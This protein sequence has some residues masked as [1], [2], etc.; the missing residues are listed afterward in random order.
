MQQIFQ[1]VLDLL[2]FFGL[3]H[4]YDRFEE[5]YK[6]NLEVE[7]PSWEEVCKDRAQCRKKGV[8]G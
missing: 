2:N 7:E 1:K 4:P 8:A 5:V 3:S 6:A